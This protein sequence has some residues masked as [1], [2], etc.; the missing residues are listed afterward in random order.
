M[1][2]AATGRYNHDVS[3]VTAS[4]AGGTSKCFCMFRRHAV[5]FFSL[6]FD[7]QFY[8]LKVVL[9]IFAV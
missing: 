6:K 7:R 5:K 3:I 4:W 2:R 1:I 8:Q 9:K